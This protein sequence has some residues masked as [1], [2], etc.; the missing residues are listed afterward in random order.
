MFARDEQG[1]L[2]RETTV[3]F[4]D[5]DHT[6][7]LKP[8]AAL[9][10]FSDLAGADYAERGLPHDVLW[11]Q[12]FVFLVSRVRAQFARPI[13]A[14][15]TLTFC[16]YEQGVK[17][18]Q[19][20]RNFFVEDADG[21]RIA[22]ARS[23]WILCDPNTRRILRPG[24]F[25]YPIPDNSA[26][27]IACPEPGKVHLPETAQSAGQR[28]VVYSDLDANGHVYNANYADITC[29]FLPLA[30][31]EKPVKGFSIEFSREALAGDVM[32]IRTVVEEGRAAAAGFV[33]DAQSF[34]CELYF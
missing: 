10:Y 2:R 34:A 33:N 6:G 16:T 11:A 21:S 5:C 31:F 14:E 27:P 13:R 32:D 22:E 15:E 9:K 8:S 28:R 24:K 18:P 23:A 19:F 7:C 25:P 4:C 1:I 26:L 3:E 17:G 20:I 12:G 29:D 30:L